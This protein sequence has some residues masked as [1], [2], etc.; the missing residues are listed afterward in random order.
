MHWVCYLLVPLVVICA[1]SED[2]VNRATESHLVT[3]LC[4][5]I[6]QVTLQSMMVSNYI[7]AVLQDVQIW[8][9]RLRCALARHGRRLLLFV[10]S[11]SVF[12]A[13]FLFLPCP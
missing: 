7:A 2:L 13:P 6:A 9:K 8:D 3:V 12:V 11:C 10:A 1:T 4:P 5:C